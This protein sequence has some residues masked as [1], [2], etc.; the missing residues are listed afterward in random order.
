MCL[1]ARCLGVGETGA[2]R[3]DTGEYY[4]QMLPPEKEQLP[5]TN[6]SFQSKPHGIC[7]E[8]SELSEKKQC[9]M[10]VVSP[11]KIS[12]SNWLCSIPQP[13]SVAC[14]RRSSKAN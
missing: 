14:V 2:N 9:I 6:L 11:G 8:I 5:F 3:I 7:A 4:S 12:I 13:K 1:A 10:G